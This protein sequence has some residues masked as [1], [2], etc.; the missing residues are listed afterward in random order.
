MVRAIIADDEPAAA[1]VIQYLIKKGSMPI[2]IVGEA[3][4]G[5]S[6]LN[7]IHL[8]S[9]ELVFLDIQMPLI[10]GFD[11]IR[12]EPS[13]KYIIVTAYESFQ[14]AQQA[15]RMGAKDILLKPVEYESLCGSI[16]RSI[17]WKLTKNDLTNDIAEYIQ[18]N[19]SE[20]IEVNELA[21]KYYT[22][23][24]HIARTFKKNMGV[25]VIRYLHS[26]RIKNAITMLEGTNKGIKEVAEDC[27]Y[28]NLNNF[29]K[30]F[31]QVTSYTPA[32]FREENIQVSPVNADLKRYDFGD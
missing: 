23:A 26:I 32:A 31:K 15:L 9:P 14:Y 28:D 11:I 12:A 20:K 7:M 30:Y 3:Y 27:G 29:Y 16:S 18:Q 21:K 5:Q 1:V 22:T 4:D 17:N 6:A 10:N 8:L 2:N 25:G 13:R 24:S 19:Y